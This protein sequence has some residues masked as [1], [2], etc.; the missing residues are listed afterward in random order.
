M[1]KPTTVYRA[2]Y[3]LSK[4]SPRNI[5]TRRHTEQTKK[6][7]IQSIQQNGIVEP[8]LINESGQIIHG[9]FR[10]EIAKE[11]NLK[12]VPVL[13]VSGVSDEEGG[14]YHLMANRVPNWDTWNFPATDDVL[15]RLDGG[16]GTEDVLGFDAPSED[17]E[18]RN[19]ARE[20]GWFIEIIPKSLSSSA[21]NLEKL[22]SLLAHQLNSESGK[23]Q[24]SDDQLLFMETMR[25]QLREVRQRMIDAGEMTPEEA[26]EK[27][28]VFSA[29]KE[30]H[31][32]A[33]LYAEAE[34]AKQR[35][36]ENPWLFP[37]K[38]DAS[39][40]IM[41]LAQFI[42]F[43]MQFRQMTQQ[44]ANDFFNSST[45]K[46]IED[47]VDQ[48]GYDHEDKNPNKDNGNDLFG[49][50]GIEVPKPRLSVVAKKIKH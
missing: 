46:E 16:L 35:K 31:Y 42:E 43:A 14:A 3:S 27:I 22:A 18:W 5:K 28:D 33:R 4:L 9:E 19:F 44:E 12:T 49:Q 21:V 1:T 20:M 39:G 32:L 2:N 15:R 6:V 7:L 38:G 17:G 26:A 36:F 10:Y 50:L 37:F 30:L 13:I 34:A 24:F 11:L 8:I 47:F 25:E 40:K 45:A 29:S 48:V 41:G 23:Y